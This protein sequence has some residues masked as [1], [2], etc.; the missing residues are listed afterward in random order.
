MTHADLL[1]QQMDDTRDWTLKL[2]DDLQGDDWTFQPRPGMAH[3]LW[4]C[5]HLAFAQMF[6]SPQNESQAMRFQYLDKTSLIVD[7]DWLP[8]MGRGVPVK[9]NPILRGL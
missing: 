5:G 2:L 4:L 8:W 9:S 7:E 1:A 6:H 3:A